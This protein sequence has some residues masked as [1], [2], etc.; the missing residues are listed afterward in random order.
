VPKPEG[1]VARRADYA[2]DLDV[3]HADALSLIRAYH[4]AGGGANT[5]TVRTIMRRE[6]VPVGAALWMPPTARAAKGLAL[7]LLGAA[8]RHKQV[9]VLSRLV[10]APSEPQN[11]AGL[12]L[13]QST[14]EVVRAQRWALIATYADEAQG[15]EGT[16]YRATGWTFDGWTVPTK[17]WHLDGRQVSAYV[18]ST[19]RT[20]AQMRALGAT[21]VVSRKRRF[22][23][24]I[25]PTPSPKAR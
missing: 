9:L 23:K 11:A 16:I 25:D 3:E 12:L 4:Y 14:R 2:F 6:G 10:V 18:A 21:C 17:T 20:I 13:G 8:D 7:R 22:V 19:P 24:L 1:P 5:S 15:H